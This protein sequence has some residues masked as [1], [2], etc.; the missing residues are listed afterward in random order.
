MRAPTRNT[1][2]AAWDLVG[3]LFWSKG[4]AT[5]RPTQPEISIFL[6]GLAPGARIAVIGAS[7]KDLVQSA[8]AIGLR[9]TVLDFS[10][11]MCAD[12]AEEVRSDTDIRVQD[13]T[14]EM[15][16]DLAGAYDA[17]ISD[18]LINRFTREEGLKALSGMLWLLKEG[19]VI[20]TS[21]KMGFYP[22]D[23]RMIEEGSRRGTLENFYDACTRTI[24][25]QAAGEVLDTCLLPHGEI[26]RAI[27]LDWY[28]GRGRESRFEDADILA[29]A[30]LVRAGDLVLGQ[31][32]KSAFPD[33]KE[34]ICY[35]FEAI[36]IRPEAR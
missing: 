8:L 23:H 34:T 16:D 36:R 6:S 15:P 31:A 30:A 10:A 5:A 11:R 29:M 28:R 12:L 26:S 25:F 9:L 35:D 21:I 19:G 2:A 14:E 33:A 3:G 32:K 24:D 7:T 18:R 13:I 17:V 22:M 1:K 20:R 4:R 27:L